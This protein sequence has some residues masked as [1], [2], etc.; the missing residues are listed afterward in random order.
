L[1]DDGLA[2]GV[3]QFHFG[4]FLDYADFVFGLEAEVGAE[5]VVEVQV[6]LLFLFLHLNKYNTSII[7]GKVAFLL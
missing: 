1:L 7:P 3:D 4:V 2:D 6:H 5:S